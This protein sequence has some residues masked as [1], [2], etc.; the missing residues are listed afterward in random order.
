[1]AYSDYGAFIWKNGENVT[2][3]CADSSFYAVQDGK[4]KKF[5]NYDIISD[6]IDC[7]DICSSGHAV[8]CF[9]TFCLEFLKTYSPIIKFTTGSTINTKCLENIKYTNKSLGIEVTGYS[10][11]DNELVNF[12]NIKHKDD[13]Y[14]VICG[15]CVGKGFEYKKLS[16]YIQKNIYYDKEREYYYFRTKHNISLDYIINKLIRLDEISF[17]KYLMWNYGIKSF[18]KD[19]LKFKIRNAWYHFND[20]LERKEVIK[21]LK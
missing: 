1:M 9:D 2:N 18:I 19:L 14:C 6:L 13:V 11:G 4:K 10:L 17:E 3:L 16:K 8:L 20:I 21:W 15:A 5:Y 7:N 12:F